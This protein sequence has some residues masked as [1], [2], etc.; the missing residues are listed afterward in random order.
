M[1]LWVLLACTHPDDTGAGVA[2]AVNDLSAR[3]HDTMG[4]IPVV[5]WSQDEVADVHAEYSADGGE[6]L[7][8][9][10][11]RYDAGGHELLLLGAPFDAEVTWRLVGG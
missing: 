5:S 6:W 11:A 2:V 3:V 1:P 7:S 9:A 8:S 10:S 4:S